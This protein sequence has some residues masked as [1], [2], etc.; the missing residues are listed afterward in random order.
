MQRGTSEVGQR[1]APVE[2]ANYDE[3]WPKKFRS[4]CEARDRCNGP[5]GFARNV[6]DSDF[7]CKPLCATERLKLERLC[8]YITRPAL[9]NDR[10]KINGQGQVELKLQTLWR[11]G[12]THHVMSPLTFMQRLAALVPRTRLRLIRFGGHITSLREMSVPPLRARGNGTEREVALKGSA[13][14]AKWH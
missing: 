14:S 10:V 2:I 5:G 6:S 11:D 3:S 4:R 13:A 9:A 12:T 7:E 8:R 1:D